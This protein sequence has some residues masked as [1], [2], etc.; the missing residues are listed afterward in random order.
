MMANFR[1]SIAEVNEAFLA[2]FAQKDAPS[3]ASTYAEDGQAFPPNADTVMGHAALT[4]MWQGVLDMGITSA[5]L[6]TIELEQLGNHACEVGLYQMMVGENVVD[7]GKFMIV[8]RRE[9]DG[10]WKWWRDMWNSSAPLT[11]G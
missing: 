9:P 1:G 10:E 8:W 4:A 2:A 3:M 6:E 7:Y 11:A 5:R